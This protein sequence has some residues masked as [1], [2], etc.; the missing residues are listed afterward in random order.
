MPRS[1]NDAATM[2]ARSMV[3][4]A[5][6]GKHRWCA[7]PARENVDL[8]FGVMRALRSVSLAC[9]IRKS[10]VRANR[11]GGIPA[12]GAPRAPGS[13]DPYGPKV[14]VGDLGDGN[15]RNW[16]PRQLHSDV[17]GHRVV[18]F[19]EEAFDGSPV[20]ESAASPL[21]GVRI[22]AGQHKVRYLKSIIRGVVYT[23]ASPQ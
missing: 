6:H 20:P 12:P 10:P 1:L 2:S 16:Q 4:I 13:A 19:P 5:E 9:V 23:R 7:L 14:D 11:S 3:V 17:F 15:L 22:P 18:G 8:R 21:T